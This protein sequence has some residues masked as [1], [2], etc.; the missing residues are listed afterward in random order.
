MGSL[1]KVAVNLETLL[2]LKGLSVP[3][4][5]PG[6]LRLARRELGIPPERMEPFLSLR[7]VDSRPED[8]EA[9]RLSA[10]WLDLLAF[11]S[12]RLE[13]SAG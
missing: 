6:I 11:L 5:R 3:P 12:R 7:R 9:R 2:R 8:A 10:A 1:P 13:E 4:D